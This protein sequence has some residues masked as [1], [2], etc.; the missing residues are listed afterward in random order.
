[1]N[2]IDDNKRAIQGLFAAQIA[3]CGLALAATLLFEAGGIG[4]MLWQIVLGIGIFVSYTLMQTPVF[5]RLFAATK[6]KGTCSFLIFLSDGCGYAA[7]VSLLFYQNF[8]S[9]GTDKSSDGNER[10]LA[11]YKAVLFGGLI[12]II[13]SLGA[14]LVFFRARL[15]DEDPGGQAT[16]SVGDSRGA[17]DP[18]A[19]QRLVAPGGGHNGEQRVR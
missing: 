17:G 10:V 11:L 9:F 13:A 2:R 19:S 1:M 6:T 16:A 7:T 8:G 15:Q 18:E 3:A 4:G 12:L 14:G 5:D